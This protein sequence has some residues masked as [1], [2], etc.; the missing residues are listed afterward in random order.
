MASDSI[1]KNKE[2]LSSKE[3]LRKSSL[4]NKKSTEVNDAAV[5]REAYR[6]AVGFDESAETTGQVSEVLVENKEQ[7]GGAMGGGKSQTYDPAQIRANLLKNLPS[8]KMMK[9]KI[10]KEIKK[11]I[12][13][14]HRKA[15]KMLRSPGKVNYFEMSNL[16]RKVREL[17]GILS[18]LV[19]AS[20][21]T[22]KT[23]WLRFVHGVL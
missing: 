6:E 21:E 14:L 5:G 12:K 17:K 8:E 15:L 2:T 7:K 4:E 11:E 10:E 20:L 16:M 18:C 22:L 1:E 19:K 23:L 3:G 9:G 13:Y